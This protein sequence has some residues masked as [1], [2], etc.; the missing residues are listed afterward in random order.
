LSSCTKLSFTEGRILKAEV[1]PE[2]NFTSKLQDIWILV[3]LKLTKLKR[4]ILKSDFQR[5]K[6]KL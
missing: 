1:K 3:Q 2:G 6:S 4:E 5:K